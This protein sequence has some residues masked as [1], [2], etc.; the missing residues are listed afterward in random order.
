MYRVGSQHS[1]PLNNKKVEQ[2]TLLRSIREPKSQDKQLSWKLERQWGKN[3]ELQFTGAKDHSWSQFQKKHWH[4]NGWIAAGL[5]WASLR[6]KHW[7]V[8]AVFEGPQHF[9]EFY[10]QDPHQVLI[11]KIEE[12]SPDAASKG[13]GD[14]QS[15]HLK[16]FPESPILLKKAAF[17]ENYFTRT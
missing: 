1:H 3:R 17:K 5:V 16:I 13:V 11:V 2:T 7:G 15:N 4:Y 14:R 10:L 8:A 12:K 6:V 9:P